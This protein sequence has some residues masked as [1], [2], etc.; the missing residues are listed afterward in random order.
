MFFLSTFC[1]I[2]RFVHRRFYRQRFL[3]QHFIVNPFWLS[4]GNFLKIFYDNKIPL[5]FKNIIGFYFPDQ[6]CLNT[7]FHRTIEKSVKTGA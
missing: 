1:P 3:L 5:P 4:E 6:K 2:G 7:P